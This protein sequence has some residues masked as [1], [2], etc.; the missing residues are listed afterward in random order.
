MSEHSN[1]TDAS[2][3]DPTRETQDVPIEIPHEIEAKLLPDMD[4][5]ELAHRIQA[6]KG[7]L[8]SRYQLLVNYH[9]HRSN[10]NAPQ[11]KTITIDPAVFPDR[12]KLEQVLTMLGLKLVEDNQAQVLSLNSNLSVRV[13][14]NR[15]NKTVILTVKD[16]RISHANPAEK[17]AD[18]REAESAVVSREQVEKLLAELGYELKGPPDEAFRTTWTLSVNAEA[19]SVQ[20][21]LDPQS[22]NKRWI[23][24][25]GPSKVSVL[26]VARALGFTDKDLV[27]VPKN[28]LFQIRKKLSARWQK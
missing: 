2:I 3:G 17:I 20:F 11:S 16:A 22:P 21:N 7:V 26:L 12:E 23:E 28:K 10:P 14:E 25:E 19:V 1:E 15:N 6:L 4:F 27:D 18:R 8:E 9:Y 5:N 24:L 13:R